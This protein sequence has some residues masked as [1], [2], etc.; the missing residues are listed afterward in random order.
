MKWALSQQ[1]KWEELKEGNLQRD[2]TNH[3]SQKNVLRNI[4]KYELVWSYV[5]MQQH[6]FYEHLFKEQGTFSFHSC[7]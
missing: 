7:Q 3:K 6:Y 4:K 5:T 2:A 1:N